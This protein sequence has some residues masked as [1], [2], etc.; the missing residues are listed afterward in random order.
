MNLSLA[1]LS[2]LIYTQR[3]T[4]MSYAATKVEEPEE[5][6]PEFPIVEHVPIM[7]IKRIVVIG[8]GEQASLVA[9]LLARNQII[10]QYKYQV[11]LIMGGR[12]VQKQAEEPVTTNG[13]SWVPFMGPRFTLNTLIYD[14]FNSKI[15]ERHRLSYLK[16]KWI[17]G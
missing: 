11:Y 15:I 2:A 1:S 13:F 16:Y 9:Y 8:D 4:S 6:Y 14:G 3:F 7:K 5:E 12:G 10:Q 17:P